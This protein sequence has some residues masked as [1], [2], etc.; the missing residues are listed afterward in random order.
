MYL[1]AGAV[2]TSSTFGYV[3][4][5]IGVP[6]GGVGTLICGVAVVGVASFASG[7]FSGVIGEGAGDIIYEVVK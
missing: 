5:V 6:A 7:A 2:L 1:A 3:Y 4:S